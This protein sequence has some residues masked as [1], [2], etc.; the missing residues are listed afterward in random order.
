MLEGITRCSYI[1]EAPLCD[2]CWTPDSTRTE[3]FS[4]V[5]LHGAYLWWNNEAV[6]AGLPAAA[7]AAA[8]AGVSEG[9]GASINKPLSGAGKH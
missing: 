5:S 8:A 9:Q 7:A 3:T 2:V 4:S 6:A 1:S